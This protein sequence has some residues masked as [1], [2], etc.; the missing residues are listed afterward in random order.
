MVKFIIKAI[1][2]G[3]RLPRVYDAHYTDG[4]FTV[5]NKSKASTHIASALE[6]FL[7]MSLTEHSKSD[8]LQRLNNPDSSRVVNI[9]MSFTAHL[10]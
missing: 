3:S 7:N 5:R 9:R 4:S 8:L 1:T 2:P 10:E 6:D